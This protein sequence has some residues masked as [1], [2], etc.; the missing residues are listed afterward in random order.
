MIFSA[1]QPRRPNLQHNPFDKMLQD[2]KKRN[3]ILFEKLNLPNG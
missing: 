1:Y 2:A 3:A